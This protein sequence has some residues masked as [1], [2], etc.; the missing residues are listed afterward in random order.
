MMRKNKGFTLIEIM[1]V[2]VIAAIMM[3]AVTL[4]F[5]RTGDDLLKEQADRFTAILSLSVDEA[6]LQSK[7]LALSVGEAGYS[8]FRFEDQNW[9]TFNESPFNARSLVGG[10]ESELLIEGVSVNLKKERNSEEKPKPQI[11]ILS[12]GEMTPFTYVMTYSNKSTVTIKVNAIGGIEQ[13]F[14]QGE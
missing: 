5:P 13:V 9:Q 12:S 10:V 14:K 6:I 2:V 4:S 7:D 8:F 3:G 1:V 11:L